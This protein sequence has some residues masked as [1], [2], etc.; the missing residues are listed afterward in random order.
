[1][2]GLLVGIWPDAQHSPSWPG[3]EALLRPAAD[4]G[5]VAIEHGPGWHVW[6]VHRN[7][8][9]IAAANVRRTVDDAVEVVLVGGCGFRE[10]LGPLDAR[11]GEWARDEGATCLRAYGRSGWARVLGWRVIG[12]KHGFTGYERLL[13]PAPPPATAVSACDTGTPL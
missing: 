10:W 4:R 3:I 5:G 7:G 9:L 1:M 13:A 2:A 6:T 8:E 12:R 11:I